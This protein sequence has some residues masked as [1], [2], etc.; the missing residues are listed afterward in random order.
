MD[1]LQSLRIV[2]LCAFL[3]LVLTGDSSTVFGKIIGKI[4]RIV[5]P[6]PIAQKRFNRT[7][8]LS[9]QMPKSAG[10]DSTAEK[11]AFDFT[12]PLKQCW[13]FADS[14]IEANKI[15]SDNEARINSV[16]LSNN[17]NEKSAN[18][19]LFIPFSDGKISAVDIFTAEKVWESDLGGR[20]A[21]NLASDTENIYLISKV[22]YRENP[23]KKTTEN[24]Q[25]EKNI[26][27][28]HFALRSLNKKSGLTEWQTN[29]DFTD[30]G[31]KEETKSKS[32]EKTEK[33]G[34]IMG[35]ITAEEAMENCRTMIAGS[36]LIVYC[37]GGFVFSV[38]KNRG[39]F[40]W[41]R[42]Y[43][44]LFPSNSVTAGDYLIANSSEEFFIVS[45]DTGEI[46][47]SF[48][49]LKKSTKITSVFYQ[50]DKKR[51]IYGDDKGTVSTVAPRDGTASDDWK[52]RSG[53]EIADISLTTRGF[54]VSSLDNFL[55][56]FAESDGELIW[57]KRLAGRIAF[58]PF[59]EGDYAA[60][61]NSAEPIASVVD[62]QTGKT[63]NKIIL[64]NGDVFTGAPLKTG[65][66]L[67]LT[68]QR[69]IFAF[70]DD[71]CRGAEN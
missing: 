4:N 55:Y 33:T 44:F 34:K 12:R 60:V 51:I 29:L 52:V 15:A 58:R 70:A 46:V 2:F 14:K 28:F 61:T 31:G 3:W 8:P 17:K 67:L 7:S 22:S 6:I 49:R 68:T 35:K 19:Y 54:L 13:F 69:G 50:P 64:E 9:P 18:Q 41:R 26:N 39:N 30:A 37:N 66:R 16:N 53:A 27:P 21:S 10:S 36:S 62:L 24:V 57:K 25:S 1:N 23:I 65:N 38:D 45:A 71:G 47:E 40:Q 20:I 11:K 42:R 32:A 56:M 59:V 48:K 5:R 43:D 63:V